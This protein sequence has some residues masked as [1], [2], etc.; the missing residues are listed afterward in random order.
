MVVPGQVS[1][2]T[3]AYNH[4]AWWSSSGV[5]FR[6]L[7]FGISILISDMASETNGLTVLACWLPAEVARAHAVEKGFGHP[8]APGI[9]GANE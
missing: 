5:N 7:A 1:P 2:Q 6:G 9:V 8:G 4:M 3:H